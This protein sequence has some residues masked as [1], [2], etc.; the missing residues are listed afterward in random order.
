MDKLFGSICAARARFETVFFIAV[1][2]PLGYKPL[3]IRL[4]AHLRTFTKFFRP[5]HYKREFAGTSIIGVNLRSMR[6]KVA[7]SVVAL[8]LWLLK[9][10]FNLFRALLVATKMLPDKSTVWV[11]TLSNAFLQLVSRNKIA[12]EIP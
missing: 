4:Y 1:L 9:K 12:R 6:L 2:T 11:I 7:C 5:R 8:V 10:D 3:R